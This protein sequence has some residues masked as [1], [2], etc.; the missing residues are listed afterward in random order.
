[1]ANKDGAKNL[2]DEKDHSTHRA[3]VSIGSI[4]LHRIRERNCG[5]INGSTVDYK[6]YTATVINEL[7]ESLCDPE[8]LAT[9]LEERAGQVLIKKLN[10]GQLK[11]IKDGT[12]KQVP[13][14]DS[15]IKL[16]LEH[17]DVLRQ[18]IKS[19]GKGRKKKTSNL[20]DLRDE[21]G[22]GG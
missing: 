20:E 13:A 4:I 5:F 15:T 11:I 6:N 21:M 7:I 1:V 10:R 9:M 2:P 17:A 14:S 19:K 22:V 16:A 18:H 12:S 8:M 3:I